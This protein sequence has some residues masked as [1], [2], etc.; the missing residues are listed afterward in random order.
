MIHQCDGPSL[1]A[2]CHIWRATGDQVR[3]IE[4]DGREAPHPSRDREGAFVSGLGSKTL[5]ENL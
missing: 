4:V 5:P 3:D 2:V 1:F